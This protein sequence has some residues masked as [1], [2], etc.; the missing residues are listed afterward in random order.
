MNSKFYC[1]DTEGVILTGEGTRGK[2]FRLYL[3]SSN[4]PYSISI[5]DNNEGTEVLSYTNCKTE[6]MLYYRLK[7][8]Y[9]LMITNSGKGRFKIL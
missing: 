5:I 3:E 6:V 7:D 1:V 9:Q 4:S 8:Y 2:P